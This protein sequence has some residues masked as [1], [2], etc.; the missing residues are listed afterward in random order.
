MSV[1]V[2]FTRYPAG[3]V[4]YQ[5]LW[6]AI[7]ALPAAFVGLRLFTDIGGVFFLYA[8]VGIPATIALQVVAGL[9]AWTYRKRQWRHLLGP[10]ATWLSAAYYAAW[11]VL[12]LVMPDHTQGAAVPAPLGRLLG[13]DG[14]DVATGILMVSIVLLYLALLAAVVVEGTRAVRRL[15]DDPRPTVT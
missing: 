2:P 6:W 7:V 5:A 13:P 12:A 15:G 14:A 4:A 10:V 8:V 9:V 1:P 11:L 3:E